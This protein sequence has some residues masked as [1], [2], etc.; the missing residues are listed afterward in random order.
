MINLIVVGGGEGFYKN[1]VPAVYRYDSNLHPDLGMQI[2]LL[3][4]IVP[5]G[6]LHPKT[7]AA[8]DRHGIQYVQ[9]PDEGEHFPRGRGDDFRRTDFLVS[10]D[11]QFDARQ[12]QDGAGIPVFGRGDADIMR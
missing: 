7:R 9:I 5:R 4:D 2:H 11:L 1:L 3:M 8:L 6:E 12:I 10:A